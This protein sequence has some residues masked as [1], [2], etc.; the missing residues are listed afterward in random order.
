MLHEQGRSPEGRQPFSGHVQTQ[1]FGSRVLCCYAAR[2]PGRQGA[3]T[4][5]GP[6]DEAQGLEP[7][8]VLQKWSYSLRRN[9][10]LGMHTFVWA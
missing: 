8:P 10:V 6:V 2:A 4:Y 9:V 1:R 7:V 3:I 5:S